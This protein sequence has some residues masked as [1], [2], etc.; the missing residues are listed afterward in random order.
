MNFDDYLGFYVTAF[1]AFGLSPY[2][3]KDNDHT[4][5][6]LRL[7]KFVQGFYCFSIVPP[8]LYYLNASV[9]PSITTRGEAIM[10]I[11]SIILDFFRSTAI[12][13]QCLLFK[14]C[15]NEIICIFQS[16]DFCF[17]KYL[18]HR[19]CYHSLSSESN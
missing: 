5:L 6:I 13:L 14:N 9:I 15:M 16:I 12:L 18:R 3:P 4:N 8:C 1:Y 19:I 17:T 7:S 10:L 2:Q 11:S